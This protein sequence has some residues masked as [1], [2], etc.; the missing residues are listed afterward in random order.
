[1]VLLLR[2]QAVAAP[3]AELLLLPPL[4]SLTRPREPCAVCRAVPGT[5]TRVRAG[6]QYGSGVKYEKGATTRPSLLGSVQGY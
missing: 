6:T 3:E 1:M 2:V 4:P 5:S